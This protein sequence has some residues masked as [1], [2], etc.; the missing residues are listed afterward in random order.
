VE[1]IVKKYNDVQHN[2]FYI[3][4]ILKRLKENLSIKDL[5]EE[6]K[7]LSSVIIKKADSIIKEE[8]RKK[9]DKKEIKVNKNNG[10][11]SKL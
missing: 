3:S 5:N 6:K 4:E 1:E 9:D 2:K 8:K 11:I 10:G 7:K